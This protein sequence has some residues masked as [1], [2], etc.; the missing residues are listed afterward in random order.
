MPQVALRVV[1]VDA[2]IDKDRIINGRV[3]TRD[4]KREKRANCGGGWK[5]KDE[6]EESEKI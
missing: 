4:S 6:D 1:V 2:G 5:E 3:R